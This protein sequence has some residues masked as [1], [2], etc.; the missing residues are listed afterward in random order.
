[1]STYR[2]F[3]IKTSIIPILQWRSQREKRQEK[4]TNYVMIQ[5]IRKGNRRRFCNWVLRGNAML[6]SSGYGRRNK[7]IKRS[8]DFVRWFWLPHVRNSWLRPCYTLF[9][10]S[11][12]SLHFTF[13]NNIFI[14]ITNNIFFFLLLSQPFWVI[15][16]SKFGQL[17][18]DSILQ[19]T[20]TNSRIEQAVK[21]AMS[22]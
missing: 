21:R 2:S 20:H 1:M 15:A 6:C 8:W 16:H 5:G 10:D 13:H 18:F 9:I 17:A 19:H 7:W 4:R 14:F 22:Q 12:I 11:P 3:S